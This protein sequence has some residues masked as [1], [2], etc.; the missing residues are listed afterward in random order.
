MLHIIKSQQA[1]KQALSYITSSD[2]IILIEDSVYCANQNH[3]LYSMVCRESV[4]VLDEDIDARGIRP[5]IGAEVR[6]VDYSGF[7][8]LTAQDIVSMTWD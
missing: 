5:Y 8:D 4:F 1:V 6:C 7:V 3:E 2:V